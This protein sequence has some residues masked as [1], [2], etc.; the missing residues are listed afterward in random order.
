MSK[1]Y[2]LTFWLHA[3]QNFKS[4]IIGPVHKP[5]IRFC[6]GPPGKPPPAS[7]YLQD[8]KS[9]SFNRPELSSG[10]K[11][12]IIIV[13]KNS[14]VEE[15]PLKKTL[16][17]TNKMLFG[18]LLETS[19]EKKRRLR[20]EELGKE[21]KK[22]TRKQK[23]NRKKKKSNYQSLIH[24]PENSH[25]M[26]L[27]AEKNAQTVSTEEKENTQQE[28]NTVLPDNKRLIMLVTRSSAE[29]ILENSSS[30]SHEPRERHL[31]D[32]LHNR[33]K[34]II[35]PSNVTASLS[36]SSFPGGSSE[37]ASLNPHDS[38][39]NHS[40]EL[41]SACT[42]LQ[43]SPFSNARDS[44]S[45]TLIDTD[46]YLNVDNAKFTAVPKFLDV[47]AMENFPLFSNISQS[48]STEHGK[49]WNRDD[50]I[51]I[52][53]FEGGYQRL[54]SVRK[55]LDETMPKASRIALERW[56][57]KLIK[58]LGEEGFK[59]Y[60]EGL[61]SRGKLLHHCIQSE[62]SGEEVVD[63]QLL[64]AEKL[65][66]SVKTVLPRV[67]DVRV[68]ES[69]LIHPYLYYQ[70]AVDCIAS[71]RGTPFLIEWKT[72]TKPKLSISSMFDD[73]LQVV[74]YLGALSYDSNYKLPQP[75]ESAI[76]VVAYESG[77]PAHVHIL[78]KDECQLYWKMWCSRLC[79]FWK[80]HKPEETP[81]GEL[82]TE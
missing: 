25:F 43:L 22:E 80:T 79:Q 59:E 34:I 77:L 52:G 49:E 74:A 38:L 81:D 11:K 55:I 45:L 31:L 27:N 17:S 23:R 42:E 56:K 44:T 4:A 71:Y 8:M 76:L 21:D 14:S 33:K 47:K 60:R 48:Y 6:S 19:Q 16:A 5:N 73:P 78:G 32:K 10:V 12:S 41:N 58:E 63:D 29:S 35:V 36:N 9:N 20:R 24:L 13:P 3:R 62:L 69:R 15:V 39:E 1:T 50:V 64:P 18:P 46:S 70:G 53:I 82:S 40:S 28:T 66:M 51:S 54:P 65:W 57:A 7:N 26:Q 37:L 75:I 61:L 67:S 2:Q 68:L 72:S 30:D